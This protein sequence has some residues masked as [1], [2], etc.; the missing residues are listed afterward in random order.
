MSN[1]IKVAATINADA[2]KVWDYYTQ[3]EYITQ[4]NFAAPSW[5]CPS[6][7]NNM[8]VGG[9][10][11]ARMEARDGSSGF[12][13]EAIYDEINPGQSFTYS[14]GDRKVTVEF[15][16]LVNQTEVIIVFDPENENPIEMQRGGWQSILDNF[17]KYTET[18]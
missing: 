2:K 10:Y 17:K 15:K 5:H 16:N 11:F 13:F 12:D 7:T 6:A 3:P 4:W 14:F 1:R 18:N 8:V 9:K